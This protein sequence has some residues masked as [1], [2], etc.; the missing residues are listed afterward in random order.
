MSKKLNKI[1]KKKVIYCRVCKSS[2]ILDL[3]VKKNFYL[4]NFDLKVPISYSVCKNCYFIF[5]SEYLGDNFLNSYYRSSPMLRRNFYT[6]YDIKQSKQCHDFFKKTIILNKKSR[7]LEIGAGS[8]ALLKYIND[9]YKCSVFYSELSKEA[10]LNLKKKKN[11][12]DLNATNNKYFDL[13]IL[14]HTLEHIHNIESFIIYLKSFLKKE[15]VLF[16]EVPDWS[17]LDVH[18]DT[19]LFEHL[20]QFNFTGLVKLLNKHNLIISKMEKSI[21]E[22]DPTSPNRVM[23]ILAV[24]S[25]FPPEGSNKIKSYCENFLTEYSSSWKKKLGLILQNFSGKKVALYPASSLTFEAINEVDFSNI[26]ITG[27]Y[28]IDKKK[29]KKM[30]GIKVFSPEKLLEHKPELILTFS[31]GYEPEIRQSL[32]NMKVQGKILSIQEIMNMRDK[33]VKKVI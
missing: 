22:D 24:S 5:Q 16:I 15:G 23:R 27:M 2:S 6:K 20:N 32:I 26:K 31:M 9:I 4:S 1:F 19:L 13:V 12:K 8:G 28:D 10:N 18:T 3:N 21:D 7:I 17:I 33:I 11:F 29:Q 25:N 14:R 30:L